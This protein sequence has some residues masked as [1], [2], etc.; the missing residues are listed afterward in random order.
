MTARHNIQTGDKVS[1]KR[2]IITLLEVVFF[3]YLLM[4]IKVI[5]FKFPLAEL[6]EIVSSWEK[7]VILEGW[8]T[9]NFIP[10]KTIKM[11]IRYYDRAYL[12]SF[13]NLFGN[14]LAFVPFGGILPCISRPCRK[15]Y[16]LF[17]N[18]ILLVTGIEVFQLIT[19]FGK[20]D[21]DDI[22]LNCLGAMLGYVGYKI[23]TN[24]AGCRK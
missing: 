20:F 16:V 5:V 11:Y 6:R 14:V 2:K 15:W 23:G 9:A 12:N 19:A 22:L 10:F 13:A 4:L 7:D 21:V 1:K 17:L 18:A 3:F 24:C 8:S